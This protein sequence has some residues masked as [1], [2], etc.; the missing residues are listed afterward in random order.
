MRTTALVFVTEPATDRPGH[1]AAL[2][3]LNGQT[4][5]DRLISQLV[6][7]DVEPVLVVARP[8]YAAAARALG[9][10]V[11]DSADVEADLRIIEGAAAGAPLLLAPGD[12]VA[13]LSA[14]GYALRVEPTTALA[15]PR[16]KLHLHPLMLLQRSRAVSVSSGYHSVTAPNA[17]FRGVL[18][19][20][21]ADRPALADAGGALRALMSTVDGAE[22]AQRNGVTSLVLLAMVRA[23]TVVAT[24]RIRLLLCTRVEDQATLAAAATELARIDEEA[25]R[26]RLAVKEHDDLFATYCVSSYS[27]RIVRWVA[28]LRLSPNQITWISVLFALA[29]AG[30]LAV[31]SRPVSVVGA[32]LLYIGFVFDCVDGQLAR[33]TL[34]FSRFGGW[35]DTI[36]DRGKEYAVYAGLAAGA[37]R[38]GIH[39]TWPLAAAALALQTVRHMTD[40]WYGALQDQAVSQIPVQPLAS[41]PDRLAARVNGAGPQLA[42]R[43]GLAL[44]RASARMESDRGS[45]AYWAKRTIVFPI[46]ERWALL[47]IAACVFDGRVAL[48]ALLGWGLLALGYTVTGRTL[49]ARA[50]RI[51]VLPA[52]DRCLQR[53]DGVLARLLGFV[54]RGWAPPLLCALAAAGPV[55]VILVIGAPFTHVPG[56]N[57]THNVWLLVA[58]GAALLAGLGAARRHDGPLDWLVPA[59]LR[60]LEYA[61]I[62]L[63]GI[64]DDVAWP[65]IFGLLAVIALFHYDL[66]A[67]VD[68]CLSPLGLRR[69]ALGWDVRVALVGVAAAVDRCE[70]VCTALAAYLVVVFVV[71]TVLGGR[72]RRPDDHVE[73]AT[74]VP[75]AR[76]WS[77]LDAQTP[78][79]RVTS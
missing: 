14:L 34:Q 50:M 63:A 77:G 79:V 25:T 18:K 33:Y 35:L 56:V 70:L 21:A 67:R 32:L 41:G 69:F 16:H 27:P 61:V 12:L 6:E 13:H 54:G 71:G 11:V 17:A 76:D 60:A 38:D 73:P 48:L 46:G 10:E 65:L 36:A 53:D 37:A 9:H 62:V 40:T 26:L 5:L 15:G 75:A 2:L 42:T 72:T 44:G 45:L 59:A 30:C 3:E 43:L 49:R 24:K 31:G 7:L 47:A 52:Y 8:G 23:G 66:A 68:K 78:A 19:V 55:G 22:L 29:A 4:L 1:A 64:N 20:S 74:V 58:T 28:R 57:V 39:H 51:A